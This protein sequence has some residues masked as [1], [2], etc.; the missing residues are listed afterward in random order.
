MG[1]EFSGFILEDF[2]FLGD[3]ISSSDCLF[4]LIFFYFVCYGVG[5]FK[6]D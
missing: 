5:I 1:L 6:I 4:G 2:Y 3:D